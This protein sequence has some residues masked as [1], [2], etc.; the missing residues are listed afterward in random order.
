[1]IAKLLLTPL[2]GEVVAR[3]IGALLMFTALAATAW[4]F[5]F[6]TPNNPAATYSLG[7]AFIY[8]LELAVAVTLL[9][10]VPAIL[11]GQLLAGRMPYRLGRD[12]LEWREARRPGAEW[13]GDGVCWVASATVP[14]WQRLDG[15][16]ST[17]RP[18]SPGG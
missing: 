11:I 15:S 9:I 3:L 17:E 1:M 10:S 16:P 2:R 7:S 8:R 4:A 13:G 12:G 18:V 5:A 14:E 6:A